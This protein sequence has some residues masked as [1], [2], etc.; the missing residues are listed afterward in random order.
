M[1]ELSETKNLFFLWI[2]GLLPNCTL[3]LEDGTEKTV[4]K[5][6]DYDSITHTLR[7]KFTD[8][9]ILVLPDKDRY[10]VK[11]PT[12]IPDIVIKPNKKRKMFKR[13]KK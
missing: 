9:D 12:S 11:I 2:E 13:H 10:V 7:L 8:G 5:V 3:I 6:L 1:I 4:E